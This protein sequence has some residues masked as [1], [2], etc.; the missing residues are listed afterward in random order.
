MSD[1]VLLD[2]TVS[3]PC[4]IIAE[5]GINHNGDIKLAKRTIE[6]ARDCGVDAV[7]F[8][9]Y[10]TDDFISDDSLDY[11]YVSGG[12]KIHE[13]QREMFKRLELTN[14]DLIELK[15]YCDALGV[16]FISTPTNPKGV[17]FLASI[18]CKRVKNGSDFLTN[19]LL[20]SAMAHSGMQVILSTGMSTLSEIDEAVRDFR[21]AGGD[22]LILLHCTSLYPTPFRELNLRRIPIL[23]QVF[24]C[25]AGFSD[26]STGSTAAVIAFVLGASVIEK[27]FTLDN[28]LPGPD[29]SFSSNPVE[30]AQLVT[31]VR[32]SYS[33]LGSTAI[34]LSD[35]EMLSRQSYRLSVVAARN[36]AA[37]IT[38]SR[39]DIKLS[40]PG[41]GI[42]PSHL[43]T[44]IGRTLA[45][46][47]HRG[48]QILWNN[49]K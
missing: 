45:S 40:R 30:M 10:E 23:S 16:E 3:N 21:N 1:H 31:S 24:S 46:P 41:T 29:H 4:F 20:V 39:D 38:I 8:Q 42:A 2:S 15:H 28:E 11:T 49:L 35:A 18:G 9:S 17:D 32:C 34:G 37:G 33:A 47:L 12:A 26:H 43:S 6:A 19:H 22:D 13:N 25:P 36:L 48:E 5:I 14:R 44:I 27:H 7:K